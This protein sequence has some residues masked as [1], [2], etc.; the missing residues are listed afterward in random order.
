MFCAGAAL[1][2]GMGAVLAPAPLRAATDAAAEAPAPAVVS[3][4]RL[5]NLSNEDLAR[6]RTAFAAQRRGDYAE[7]D[8]LVGELG[9]LLLVGHLLHERYLDTA[10]YK[11]SRGELARWL[12]AYGDLPGAIDIETLAAEGNPSGAGDTRSFL[13]P[14]NATA[15]GALESPLDMMPAEP[16]G[17]LDATRAGVTRA[18][19]P[20]IAAALRAD[21]PDQ[22]AQL[23]DEPKVGGRLDP[24]QLEVARA[25]IAYAFYRNG[26]DR[27]AYDMAAGVADRS[28]ADIPMADWTAGLA[29]WRLGD[30][31]HAGI[32]F[33]ALA[34]A[35]NV[36]V[37]VVS[38]AAFWAARAD[39]VAGKPERV[40][41]HLTQAA[42]Y[43]NTFY[44]LMATRLLGRDITAT[45][46]LG[47][48]DGRALGSLAQD[49]A[50]QRAAALAAV[51]QEDLASAELGLV[52]ARLAPTETS[53]VD[54][55]AVQL[56][57]VDVSSAGG[58]YPVPQWR[59]AD[60][61]RVDRALLFAFAKQES[62][63]N[64]RARSPVG[65]L[66]LM[67]LMPATARIVADRRG[68][69]LGRKLAGLTEPETNL[70]L[71]QA[72]LEMLMG[73]PSIGSNLFLVAA[74]YNAGPGAAQHW[75]DEVKFNGDPLLFIESIPA[76]ETRLFIER[77]LANFWIY[78][79]RLGQTLETLDAAASGGW[80]M[81]V[82]QDREAIRTGTKRNAG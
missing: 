68:I 31:A 80:P 17:R 48:I 4:P 69:D 18:I 82:P 2:I 42:N 30:A 50:I 35:D 29:A 44:G 59:P 60:G 71:G 11:A 13:R 21:R 26:D 25:D 45:P 16:L 81:Y 49:P 34:E 23:L 5:H 22:A 57:L 40:L 78:Q 70:S 37:W 73:N 47:Q 41:D 39:L 10:R 55:I 62:G 8:R 64:V 54:A 72:Y 52:R 56:G 65:A 27:N 51:G 20:R 1:A 36:S 9:N 3:V 61:L 15:L 28:R 7:A 67:Q 58:R 24:D 6:Y 43:P 33:S 77:I 76:A 63:F 53:G 32:H 19:A 14:A 74:A 79:A 12:A 38:A 46:E 75:L 66:G